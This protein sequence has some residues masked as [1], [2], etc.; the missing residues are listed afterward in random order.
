MVLI[1]FSVYITTISMLVCLLCLMLY[2]LQSL[3]FVSCVQN[4]H[5]FSVAVAVCIINHLW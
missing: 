5:C 1:S 2:S 4:Y 3:V